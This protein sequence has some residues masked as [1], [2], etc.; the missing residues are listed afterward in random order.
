MHKKLTMPAGAT[1]VFAS[2][3]TFA[4]LASAQNL[5]PP[6]DLFAY[7]PPWWV[8][9]QGWNEPGYGPVYGGRSAYRERQIQRYRGAAEIGE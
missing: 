7:A 5:T 8:Q 1:V 3:M 2:A 4:T 6:T 9:Q